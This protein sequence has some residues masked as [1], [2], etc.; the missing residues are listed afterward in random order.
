MIGSLGG[1]DDP[2]YRNT[3]AAQRPD[4]VLNI[5]VLEFKLPED[6]LNGMI[7]KRL[8]ELFQTAAAAPDPVSGNRYENIHKKLPGLRVPVGDKDIDHC[9]HLRFSISSLLLKSVKYKGKLPAELSLFSEQK[10]QDTGTVH[11]TVVFRKDIMKT[12]QVRRS[13]K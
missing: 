10:R 4:T 11:L 1:H 6:Q 13:F 8:V 5:T 2:V 12:A 9:V 7:H 3:A